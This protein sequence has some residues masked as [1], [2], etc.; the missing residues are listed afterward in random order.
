M[1]LYEAL[2]LYHQVKLKKTISINSYGTFLFG[3][4]PQVVIHDSCEVT[5]MVQGIHLNHIDIFLKV[6][7][8]ILYTDEISCIKDGTRYEGVVVVTLTNM[9]YQALR[10]FNPKKRLTV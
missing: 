5:I 3:D 7:C 4:N 8:E 1:T 9:R 6:P 2:L 10:Y